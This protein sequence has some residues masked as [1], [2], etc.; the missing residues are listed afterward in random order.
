MKV[1]ALEG[2]VLTVPDLE[3]LVKQGPVVL[4]RNGL[5]LMTVKD[6]TGSDW[7]SVSLSSDPRFMAII[8]ESRRSY[9][10]S[11]GIDLES[12][13]QELG[14]DQDEDEPLTADSRQER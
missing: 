4:T 2:N 6:V 5:P 3:E 10:E 11:G 9:R 7:E 13:R 12:L 8:E 14:F 1:I